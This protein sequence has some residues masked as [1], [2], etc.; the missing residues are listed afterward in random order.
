M[1]EFENKV[2]QIAAGH[3]ENSWI[4]QL[5]KK[6]SNNFISGNDGI[7]DDQMDGMEPPMLDETWGLED[8]ARLHQENSNDSE[9][10]FN[11]QWTFLIWYSIMFDEHK[12]SI[13]T[14]NLV[15]RYYIYFLSE[16]ISPHT[17]L[18]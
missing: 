1:E 7:Q 15:F 18:K 10:F 8:I 16:N 3:E 5:Y 9:L 17:Y 12:T 6:L 13:L 11:F 14:F 4:S 2:D